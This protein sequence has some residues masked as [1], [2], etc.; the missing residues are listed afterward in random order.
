MEKHL[1]TDA[2]HAAAD[3]EGG[4]PEFVIPHVAFTTGE[5]AKISNVS[6]QTIIRSVDCNAL[7][8][9]RVPDSRFRRISW[10]EAY[11]FLRDNRMPVESL[12]VVADEVREKLDRLLQCGSYDANEEEPV[13]GVRFSTL[14]D[15]NIDPSKGVYTTGEAGAIAMV[16]QQTIIRA[17]DT[18]PEQLGY[19][20]PLSKFRRLVRKKLHSWMMSLEIPTAILDEKP[21]PA[22]DQAL[23]EPAAIAV[24]QEEQKPTAVELVS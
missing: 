5:M 13:T 16:S 12:G 10:A 19:K 23:S 22:V 21:R 6:Q 15:L 4:E 17:F 18:D 14:E 8:G 2:V 3:V 20:V 1:L 7:K 9:F 24:R 11:I